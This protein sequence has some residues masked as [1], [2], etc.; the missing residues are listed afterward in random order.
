M[1]L[2][3]Q[4]R[5]Q[6]IRRLQQMSRNEMDLTVRQRC[7]EIVAMLHADEKG[8]LFEAAAEVAQN[9][10]ALAPARLRALDVIAGM[11]QQ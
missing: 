10:L 3:L 1:G 5:T 4:Q 11:L 2:T 6:A 8:V 9:P 7:Q